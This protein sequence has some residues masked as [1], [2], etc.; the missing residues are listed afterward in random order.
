M[1][2]PLIT[3]LLFQ[4]LCSGKQQRE[5]LSKGQVSELEKKEKK[6]RAKHFFKVTN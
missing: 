2:V 1:E 6:K 5:R 4:P 3:Q